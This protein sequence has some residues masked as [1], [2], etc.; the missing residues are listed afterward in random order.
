[1]ARLEAG[2]W[3]A[4]TPLHVDGWKIA[5]CPVNGPALDA[6]GPRVV[7]AWFTMVASRP[8]VQVAFSSNGGRSFGAPIPVS[9]SDPLGRV[10]V[11]LLPDGSA[12]V[13]WLE[14]LGQDALLRV[15]RSSVA[16][17]QAQPVTVARTSAA[18]ASGFP[19]MVVS[20]DR[21]Y[22]GWAETKDANRQRTATER[23]P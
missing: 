3:S 6:I 21:A 4:P 5:G 2:R 18:R 19:R 13:S 7:A 16:G 10:D 17:T 12:L 11:A 15:Q 20:G 14:A 8:R 22:F 9:A 23:I 1:M